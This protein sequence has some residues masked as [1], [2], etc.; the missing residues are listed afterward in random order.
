VLC[1]T[2]CRKIYILSKIGKSFLSSPK[3]FP[4]PLHCKMATHKT[5]HRT[6]KFYFLAGVHSMKF[7]FEGHATCQLSLILF[8]LIM[9]LYNDWQDLKTELEGWTTRLLSFF[10]TPCISLL[11]HDFVKAYQHLR[12]HTFWQQESYT[13]THN[14]SLYGS[15]N[16]TQLQ[17]NRKWCTE[18][19]EKCAKRG[20]FFDIKLSQTHKHTLI[21]IVMATE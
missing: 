15:E 8:H 12:K 2:P 5:E 13:L 14:T 16:R 1:E 11:R 10:I 20:L 4:F 18:Q 7:D 9:C 6:Q 19:E 21:M 17:S 3:R